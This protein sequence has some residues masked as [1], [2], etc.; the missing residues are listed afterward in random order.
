MN[1]LT[2]AAEGPQDT[3]GGSGLAEGQAPAV[4]LIEVTY[5]GSS[6]SFY[7]QPEDAE[8]TI[9]CPIHGVTDAWGDQAQGEGEVNVTCAGT[10]A[11]ATWHPATLI[12]E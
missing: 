8:F 9:E 6:G 11:R 3:P 2:T 4:R 12:I 7:D 5:R 1:T 10:G